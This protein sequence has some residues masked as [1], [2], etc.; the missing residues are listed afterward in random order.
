MPL[1]AP[2]PTRLAAKLIGL[3]RKT[4]RTRLKVTKQA[5]QQLYVGVGNT[6][7]YGIASGAVGAPY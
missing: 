6:A 5:F 3:G 7:C 2:G 4:L 1:N